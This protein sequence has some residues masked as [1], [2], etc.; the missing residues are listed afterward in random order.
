MTT[1][2]LAFIAPFL[3]SALHARKLDD[4]FL[5]GEEA[6]QKYPFYFVASCAVFC[7]AQCLG[8]LVVEVYS[9]REFPI[10]FAACSAHTLLSPAGG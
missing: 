6:R 2:P 5:A 4:G 8:V 10:L 7:L 9:L 1:S 3:V